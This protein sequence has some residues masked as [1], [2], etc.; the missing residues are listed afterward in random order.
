MH[1]PGLHAVGDD[2]FAAIHGRLD[3]FVGII[4]GYFAGGAETSQLSNGPAVEGAQGSVTDR[5]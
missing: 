1:E 3:H 4:T 2:L 5:D